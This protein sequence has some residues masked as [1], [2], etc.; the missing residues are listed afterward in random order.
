MN[1]LLT[2]PQMA[3]LA[4]AASALG[5]AALADLRTYQI[6]NRYAAA[7]AL[8]FV[9]FSLGAGPSEAAV[10]FA[11]GATAF[12][13]GTIFFARRWLGGGDVKLLAAIALWVPPPLLAAFTV[14]TSLAGA[15]LSLVMLTPLR[16][17]LPAPPAGLTFSGRTNGAARAM[18][19]PIP[20]AIAIAIGGLFVLFK[21]VTG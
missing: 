1:P 16:G 9:V 12:L 2:I 8:A 4:L 7:I 19:Q 20:F 10:G 17:F 5:A 14:A 21:R 13:I 15:A 11:I 3:A 6:P 18:R